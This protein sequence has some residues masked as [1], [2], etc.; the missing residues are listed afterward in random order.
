MLENATFRLL[1]VNVLPLWHV[2]GAMERLVVVDPRTM[3]EPGHAK[4]TIC[5]DKK[6]IVPLLSSGK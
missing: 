4:L 2:A 5:P 1:M 6:E 3:F